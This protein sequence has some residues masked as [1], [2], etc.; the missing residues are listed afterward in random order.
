MRHFLQL[1]VVCFGGGTGLP[2]LL[3]GL[4]HNPWF[5]ITAIVNMFDS[6]GS[7]GELKDRFGI[8]PPGD[9]LKCLLA[10][11]SHEDHAREMLLKKI[12]NPKSSGHTGGNALLLGLEKI[13]GDYLAAVDAL[14]QLLSIRGKVIPVTQEQTTL[15]ALFR[16][17]FTYRSETGVDAGISEGKCVKKIFLEPEVKASEQALKAIGESDLICIGPGSFYTSVLSN[18]LPIGIQPAVR[19]STARVLFIA[20]FLTEGKGMQNMYL[21]DMVNIVEEHAGRPM[22]Y[23]IVNNIWP[24]ELLEIY[25]SENKNPIV[26]RT[27]GDS[28]VVEA[29]LWQD[30]E[31]A[32]HDSYRLAHLIAG[33]AHIKD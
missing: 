16:D 8:L 11:S 32:R 9:I 19:Q 22:D 31:I 7:S 21:E 25:S 4:K 12:R 17:G 6:G 15:C 20:N 26:A 30:K 24:D 3:S 33:L 27:I 5:D 1:K 29:E 10:L 2:S 23:I 18:F 28:R 14:G 13:Y